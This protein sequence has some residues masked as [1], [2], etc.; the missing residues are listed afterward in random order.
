VGLVLLHASHP[1][2]WGKAGPGLWYLPLGVGVA[3][4]AWLGP[5]A[6]LL[7]AVDGLLAGLQGW[8]M[9]TLAPVGGAGNLLLEVVAEAGL[10]G[11]EV[12]VAWRLYFRAARQNGCLGDPHAAMVFL[13]IIPGWLTGVFGVLRLVLAQALGA[14]AGSYTPA[15]TADPWSGLAVVWVSRALAVLTLSPF[16]WVV[17]GPWLVRWGWVQVPRRG[18]R[19]ALGAGLLTPP[20]GGR[21]RWGD[22]IELA[23]LALA[24]GVLG[25]VV[26]SALGREETTAWTLWG[27]PLL[28]IVWACLR[29]GVRGGA[30]VAATTA[31]FCLAAEPWVGGATR[32]VTPLQLN[33][34]A[35]CITA[36]LAGASV[37]W[38][39]VNEAR[40]RQVVGHIP[41][42]LYSARFVPEKGADSRVELTFVSPASRL[43]LGQPPEQL[44]G[45][46]GRWLQVVHPQDREL[47]VAALAQLR[48]DR[49]PISCEYRVGRPTE[50]AAPARAPTAP[51][52]GEKWVRDTRTPYLGEGGRLEG[53]DGVVEDITEQRALAVDLRRTTGMLHALV[54]HLPTGVFFVQ[55]PTGQ[56]ILVN[57]RAR[58]LLGQREDSAAGLAQLPAIYRLH[59][60]DG[61]LY[62]ADELP[63][64]KALRKG[65]SCLCDDIVVHRPDGRRLPLVTWA[66]PVNLGRPGKPG[67]A[68]WVFEDLTA[69]HQAEAARLESEARMRAVIDTMA[70]GLIVQEARGRIIECNPA[71]C[72]ILGQTPEELRGRAALGLAEGC[73]REDGGPLPEDEQPAALSLRTGR[74]V[75]GVVLGLPLAPVRW[76]LANAMPLPAAG[77]GKPARVVTTF[78]DITATREALAVARASEEKYRGLLESL[79]LM[80]VLC[81]RQLHLTYLN[82]ATTAITGYTLTDFP[83]PESWKALVHPDDLP[84]LR[85]VVD[86]ALAGKPGRAELR[87]R[88][89]DGSDKV[90]YSLLQPRTQDKAVVGLTVLAVDM[91]LQRQLE[92]QLQRA[93]RLEQVGRL[94]SGIA[95]DFNNLLTVVL[96]LS[97]LAREGLPEHH[98]VHD[99]LR[100][101][102]EAGEQATR[103]AGQL[104]TFSKQ[105]AVAARPI[106]V[107]R[108]AA[109]TLELLRGTLCPLLTVECRF[110][111]GLPPAL[112]DE[113]QLQQV[114]M[115]LFLNARDAM[116]FGGQLTVE[117]RPADGRWVCLAVQDTGHGMAEDVRGR[118]FDPFFST[119]ERGTGLGLAMVRQIVENFGGRIEVASQPG[120][121]SC[122]EVWLPQAPVENGHPGP[123]VGLR[124]PLAA[125]R[126]S[127]VFPEVAGNPPAQP[128]GDDRVGDHVGKA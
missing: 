27:V 68:V 102:S 105:R 127:Q 35:Q 53:W 10:T 73:V 51:R 113:T 104:L 45:D 108:V 59:R 1:L 46:F 65:V 75:R 118:I 36:L 87:Y 31:V 32:R 7:V 55:D 44:E 83:G 77:P 42:V 12:W 43:L 57:A 112:A 126:F 122:F 125:H 111:P 18:S 61:T 93:Q 3:L 15:L 81:D 6:A 96:T 78:V 34:L 117:T 94:A 13:L 4:A 63:V 97:D 114:L 48:R 106:D 60:P 41:V 20:P 119:K 54:A 123:A 116:P 110:W 52:P 25:L 74:A 37:S 101:I 47:L 8:L 29:Q 98:P 2:T 66:A 28:L 85:E 62:P 128:L 24:T 17:A 107:N 89:K 33:L 30:V 103:L 38:I 88:S 99:N 92:Q 11:L 56:P 22:Q 39:R 115:N 49:R 86:Q 40:Y 76:I 5:L 23:G 90:C 82:P 67:A 80:L 21:L 121:G 14:A 19:A 100:H 79:P 26:G 69:L 70:E 124:E 109:Q 9:G 95:H 58:Q 120:Y 50:P 84:G 64:A 72:A 71:A 91:T 16:L